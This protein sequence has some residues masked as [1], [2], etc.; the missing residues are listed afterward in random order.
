MQILNNITNDTT[1]FTDVLYYDYGENMVR[2]CNCGSQPTDF[3]KSR[4]DV[5]WVTEGLREFNWVKGGACP[6]YVGSP[7]KLT[8][9]RL[10]R[11]KGKYVMLIATGR[12]LDMPLD[13]INE[14]NS[15]QPH[16]FAKLDCSQDN[17][18]A[19]IRSNHIH[20]VKGDYKKVL[21]NTC[22]VLDIAPILPD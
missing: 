13:K 21:I 6:R 3:A 10:S 14:T 4:K 16:I 15:Q 18:I 8:F 12:A 20:L 5:V 19:S 11:I 1:I 2:L 9:A 22:E 17:F 7:G